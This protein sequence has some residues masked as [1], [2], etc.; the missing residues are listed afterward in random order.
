M[1]KKSAKV[2]E[3][4]EAA[5]VEKMEKTLSK[6]VQDTVKGLRETL[7]VMTVLA[8]KTPTKVLIADPTPETL[9]SS[10][11]ACAMDTS[12]TDTYGVIKLEKESEESTTQ[13]QSVVVKT[14]FPEPIVVQPKQKVEKHSKK[15]KSKKK[16]GPTNTTTPAPALLGQPS[17]VG[18]SRLHINVSN[19]SPPEGDGDQPLASPPLKLKLVLSPTT[20]APIY[21]SVKVEPGTS[22]DVGMDDGGGV[23]QIAE[24][25]PRKVGLRAS[26]ATTLDNIQE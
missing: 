14:E 20:E 21:N 9:A 8:K 18:E 4:E 16:K 12:T 1:R 17:Y 23:L 7:G 10:G 13:P 15:A 6:K 25:A 11:S 3:M 2:L 19:T 26:F 5:K 24:P 22:Y